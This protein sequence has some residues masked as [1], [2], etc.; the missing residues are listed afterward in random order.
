ML[1]FV[2]HMMPQ[3]KVPISTK[4]TNNNLKLPG[5]LD[6]TTALSDPH[7]TSSMMAKLRSDYQYR[8]SSV[9]NRFKNESF[10]I[11]QSISSNRNYLY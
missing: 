2:L 3:A 9:Q 7:L 11:E 1:F 6:G 10:G 5:H 4:I 8:T